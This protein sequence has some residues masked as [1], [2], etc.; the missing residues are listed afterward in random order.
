MLTR[1]TY[2]K[3]CCFFFYVQKLNEREKLCKI[4]APTLKDEHIVKPAHLHAPL[5]Q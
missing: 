3:Y 2:S 1:K 4:P 5:I